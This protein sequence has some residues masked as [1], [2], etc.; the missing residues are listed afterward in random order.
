ME[1]I[2]I[3]IVSIIAGMATYYIS[4]I[5]GK[6]AVFGSAIVVLVSGL[7]FRYLEAENMIA[8]SGLAVV[9]T[10][11]TYTGMVAQKNVANLK[12]MAAAGFI[13]ALL[14]IASTNTFAGVGGRLGTIAALACFTWIGIKKLLG[15]KIKAAE[16]RY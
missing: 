3:I 4:V 9:A 11:A 5:M 13:T 7:L 12:E 14:Y 6:G 2:L 10:T 8:I 15:N 1:N 16:P